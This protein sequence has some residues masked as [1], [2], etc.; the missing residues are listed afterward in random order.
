MLAG[1]EQGRA[2]RAA[3]GGGGARRGQGA[4]CACTV[5]AKARRATKA[6]KATR[7]MAADWDK[8]GMILRCAV[9][10]GGPGRRK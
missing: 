10:G 7:G 6:A 3:A 5:A 8:L 2:Q 4:P 1:A 9:R